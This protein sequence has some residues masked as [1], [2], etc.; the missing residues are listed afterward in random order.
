MSVV[1]SQWDHAEFINEFKASVDTDD[2]TEGSTNLYYTQARA[3]AR[4]AAALAAYFDTG[5]LT[6]ASGKVVKVNNQQVVGARQ[7]NIADTTGGTT[8][9][10]EVRAVVASIL[11][12]LEAHGLM[13]A[14][15]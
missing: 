6:L 8:V 2:I 3:D 9:D 14:A 11:D 13:A 7:A 1:N 15:A 12:L 10:A 4:A 5:N